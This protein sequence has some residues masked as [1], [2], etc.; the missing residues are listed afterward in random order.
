M[1]HWHSCCDLDG[2]LR[3]CMSTTC[4]E[5]LSP[6]LSVQPVEM[7]CS[8]RAMPNLYTFRPGDGNEVA[9]SYAAALSLTSSPSVIACSR[10][11]MPVLSGTSIDRVKFGAYPLDVSTVSEA[12]LIIAA[13][14]SEL[15]IAAAG[16]KA[17]AEM[18]ISVSRTDIT[19]CGCACRIS[20]LLP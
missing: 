9:G 10:T 14:G 7:L 11:G 13:T 4:G 5:C 18:G 3:E 6:A 17:L 8:L 20:S 19:L 16:A 1:R 12:K 2:A 15:E